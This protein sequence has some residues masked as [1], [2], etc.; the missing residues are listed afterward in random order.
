[1]K[2]FIATLALASITAPVLAAPSG[3]AAYSTQAITPKA[4]TFSNTYTYLRCWYREN[5]DAGKPATRYVWA[6]DPASS[7]YYRLYGNW[8]ADGM[9]AW[10]NMFYTDTTQNEMASV[11]K[12][13]LAAAGIRQP[14]I[15]HS[16]ADSAMSFDYTAWTRANPAEQGIERMVAFGDSLSDNRNMFN[17]SLW[18]LP[19]STS[20]YRGH[21]SNGPVWVE[22][23]SAALGLPLYNWAIG[24]AAAD[25]HLVVPGLV[26]Q[27]ESF[28][29]Y[30]REDSGYRPENTLFT[31]LIGGNDLVNYGKSVDAII[32][33]EQ[34]AL[35]SLIQ[36]GGKHILL[37]NL[38]DVS[39]AP[40]FR[41][42]KDGAAVAANVSDYNRRL[43]QLRD[44]LAQKYGSMVDLRLFDTRGIFDDLLTHPQNYAI[45]N[46][47]DNCLDI[48]KDSSLNYVES[49]P[50]SAACRNPDRYVFWDTLHPTRRVHQLLAE[51]IL[52]LV[53][54][55]HR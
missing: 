2:Q 11:C 12:S 40:V 22:N 13:S 32:R 48:R 50:V 7:D 20:W 43:A 55:L 26:Q 1:M 34:Q 6:R 10:A 31:V 21:F 46:A 9:F 30:L 39:R 23:L 38:P 5:A 8:R 36:A 25:Q 54:D 53:A 51:K 37:L 35:E 19:N 16:A 15:F 4:A 42:R 14:Y 3:P 27:V 49:H 47:R 24:G 17:A 45:D 29:Y 52:P 28:K 41:W 18:K 44:T 33:S